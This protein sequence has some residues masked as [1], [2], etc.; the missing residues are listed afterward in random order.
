VSKSPL[1]RASHQTVR[2]GAG[3]HDSPDD[4]ACVMELAS[5]LAGERFSDHPRSVSAVIGAF[6]R[7]YNDAVPDD[8]RQDLYPLAAQV[9]GTAGSRKVERARERCCWDWLGRLHC[10]H[11]PER[12]SW[13]GAFFGRRE[14]PA[15]WL[16]RLLAGLDEEGHRLA[17]RLVDELVGISH[18]PAAAPRF[19]RSPLVAPHQETDPREGA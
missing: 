9:V 18:P 4:G 14:Q 15:P 19:E 11:L 13:L 3:R 2:I 17:F 1:S 5:M 8:R 6:L 7:T 16:A 12:G 10:S